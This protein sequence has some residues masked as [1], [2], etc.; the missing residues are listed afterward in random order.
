MA[1]PRSQKKNAGASESTTPVT[2]SISSSPSNGGTTEAPSP[3][4]AGTET[5][6]EPK[7]ATRKPEIVRADSRANIVPINLEEEIRRLAYLFSERRGFEPG[8]ETEDW[9]SA[10][11]EVLQRYRQQSA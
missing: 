7:K 9:L 6:A 2:A 3:L 10:E 4:V 5:Q 8:H 1:K 11:N